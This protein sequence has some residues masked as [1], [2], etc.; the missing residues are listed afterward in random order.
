MLD[1]GLFS[2]KKIKGEWCVNAVEVEWIQSIKLSAP[3][4]V[5]PASSSL[6]EVEPGMVEVSLALSGIA[7]AIAAILPS[8]PAVAEN[9]RLFVALLA[10][11]LAV[12]SAYSALW[13]LARYCCPETKSLLGFKEISALLTSPERNGPYWFVGW[14][15]VT[16]LVL[17]VLIGAL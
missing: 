1:D 10:G 4:L 9:L 15:L 6:L 14:G 13:L 16:W 3:L 7:A 5:P 2:G 8:I 12:F 17:S 11:I